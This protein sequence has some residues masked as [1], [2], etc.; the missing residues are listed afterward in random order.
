MIVRGSGSNTGQFNLMPIQELQIVEKISTEKN[1][2]RCWI[3]LHAFDG[4]C[5]ESISMF[6][7]IPLVILGKQRSY[8]STEIPSES[9][10]FGAA[11]L[12]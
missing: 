3:S 9:V 4:K 6:A 8:Y 10:V 1:S 12:R 11:M 2:F 5:T 7:A